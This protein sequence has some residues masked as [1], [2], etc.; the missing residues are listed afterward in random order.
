MMAELIR[1]QNAGTL[2][3]SA[4]ALM[5]SVRSDSIKPPECRNAR[6]LAIYE[7][8]RSARFSAALTDDDAAPLFSHNPTYQSLFVKGFES[9]TR[10]EI[11]LFLNT[12]NRRKEPTPPLGN[13][14]CI[15]V[16]A[17]HD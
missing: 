14:R 10:D 16:R 13:C 12:Y 7:R 1:S 9:V 8:G 5:N 2:F 4:M 3:T 6:Y 15:I 17:A 11:R